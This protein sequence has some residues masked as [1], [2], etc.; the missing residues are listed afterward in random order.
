MAAVNTIAFDK[1]AYNTGDTITV[2]VD[3]AP[4]TPSTI[5]TPF[6]LTAQVSDAS[7]NPVGSPSTS[8]FSVVSTQQGDTC[9]VSDSGTRAW[10][11]GAETVE[12]DGSISQSFTAT[13]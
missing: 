6:T 10:T 2:T 8:T 4:D 5:S 3:F 12:A 7:G 9:G 11:A 1:A 13:A